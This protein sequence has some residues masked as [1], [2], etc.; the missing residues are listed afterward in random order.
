M[1]HRLPKKVT[2]QLWDPHKCWELVPNPGLGDQTSVEE[3]FFSLHCTFAGGSSDSAAPLVVCS[4]GTCDRGGFAGE[5][6]SAA[7]KPQPPRAGIFLPFRCGACDCME[8]FAA[9]RVSRIAPWV[10]TAAV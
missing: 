5:A 7:E 8:G 4:R 9:V 3:G 1:R 6:S 10:F 2:M